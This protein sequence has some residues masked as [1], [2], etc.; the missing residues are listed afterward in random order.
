MDL[1]LNRI[2]RLLHA[3]NSPHTRFQTIH[4]AGT[5]G[6]GSVCAYTSS[7]LQAAGY[8]VGRYNSPHLL[9]PRDAIRVDGVAPTPAEFVLARNAVAKADIE[10][11]TCAMSFELLTA[12]AF[13]WFERRGVEVAVVEV[14]LGGRLDATNVF[15]RPAVSIVTAIGMDHANVLGNTVEKIAME[16]AGIMKPRSRVVIAPQSEMDAKRALIQ[17]AEELGCECVLVEPARWVGGREGWANV[18]VAEEGKADVREISFPIPLNGHYQLENA[19][20]AVRAVHVLRT[21]IPAFAG[22]KDAHIVEGMHRTR[23]PGR[24]DIVTGAALSAQGLREVIVDGAHNPAAARPLRTFVDQKL[25]E[26]GATGKVRWVLAATQGKDIGEIVRLLVR[27]GDVVAAA[28]FS[29]PEATRRICPIPKLEN[30]KT[31][32]DVATTPREEYDIIMVGAGIVGCAVAKAFGTDGRKVLLVERDLSEPDRI[33][34]ELLQPGG[35]S[36]LKKLGMEECVNG[37]DGIPCYGYG[38]I[39][40]GEQVHIPYPKTDEGKKAVGTSFHHGRF[41]QNLRKSARAAPNVTTVEGTANVLIRDEDG[42][43]VVGVSY[44][45]KGEKEE[46][47]V[48]APLTI[49]ADGLFSKFRKEFTDKTPD[50][51]SNFVGEKQ[52]CRAIQTTLTRKN[53]PHSS[54]SSFILT[55]CELPFPHHGHVILANPAPVLLYQI[56]SH[57]TRVLVDVPGKLPSASTGALKVKFLEALETERLRSM[58]NGFLPPSSNQTDGLLV[59]GD[60][61][62]IR[63]PLTGATQ[64]SIV[65]H[66]PSSILPGGMTV[67]FNDVCL[68]RDLLSPANIPNLHDT[69]LIL[70]QLSSYFWRRKSYSLAINVLA[71]ALYMLFAA[72]DDPNLQVLQ[73]GC[74]RYFQLGGECID[75]PV[76]LLS[77]LNQRPI[78]LV[79]HF[80]RV[81]FYAVYRLF[82]DGE[83]ND[84][85]RN[86]IKIFT[87]IWAACVVIL[88]LLWT[89][90]QAGTFGDF[91]YACDLYELL[92]NL[93]S[94]STLTASNKDEKTEVDGFDSTPATLDL[95]VPIVELGLDAHH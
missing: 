4:V 18:L 36:T 21:T 77:G 29:Q 56:G 10:A 79:Y 88:P 17:K 2:H 70:A 20:T 61:A 7:I 42:H 84:V 82:A 62:N 47:Q 78:V 45:P 40:H 15:E 9:E 25:L 12:A 11:E 65:L 80:F 37:I 95:I 49:V 71:M 60:A 74:F 16:K 67:A 69:D 91:M 94:T 76:G 86:F 59:L 81:A 52:K 53:R 1:G 55:D 27:P 83:W 22:I 26:S 13:W 35:M 68:L 64:L 58:P 63:H 54:P 23:W 73:E 46:K 44:L 5:N 39:Y 30:K 85:P 92:I 32:A 87:V 72:A 19:A 38:V 51:K 93:R 43:K 6:K 66:P 48:F 8:R 3:L 28:E 33:V 90:V 31:M 24:L 34:G 89:E 75:G 50:V 14:G 41:I 57:E